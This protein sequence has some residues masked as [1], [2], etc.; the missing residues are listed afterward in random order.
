MNEQ[1]KKLITNGGV[2]LAVLVIGVFIGM[3]IP[4]GKG[5]ANTFQA[6]WDAAKKRLAESGYAF[7]VAAE[8]TTLS[9]DVTEVKN[10]S[11]T[12][13]IRPLEP[14]ADPE[15]DVRTVTFDANTKFYRSEPKDPAVYQKEM[16][17]YGRKMQQLSGKAG[18]PAPAAA[19]AAGTPP[20]PTVQKEITAADIQ[21]GNMVI[22]TAGKNIKEEKTFVATAIVA[23]TVVSPASMAA[24]VTPR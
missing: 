22:V 19:A 23:Q 17:E 16:E 13:K 9:G 1:T 3:A 21:K 6:G 18:T 10:G 11:L 7:P 24:P 2:V 8:V 4:A 5:G 14:L 12:M 20:Q 15:L